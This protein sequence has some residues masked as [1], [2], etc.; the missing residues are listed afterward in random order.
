MGTNPWLVESIWSF[1]FLKC[2][3]C[4]FNTRAESK[5]KI[6]ATQKH[7]L[8]QVLFGRKSGPS[9]HQKVPKKQ[10]PNPK[11]QPVS[12]NQNSNPNGQLS[13]PKNWPGQNS[14]GN[15]GIKPVENQKS[16]ASQNTLVILVKK[17]QNTRKKFS[18]HDL[19]L[20]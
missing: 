2:P 20:G 14:D 8:S 13:Y 3:E 10:K 5:F 19:F 1:C 18:F 9:F 15:S 4:I 17:L 7:P 16:N 6:H 12:Q 11:I